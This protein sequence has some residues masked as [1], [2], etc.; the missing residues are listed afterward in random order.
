MARDFDGIDDFLRVSSSAISAYPFTMAGWFNSDDVTSAQ[1]IIQIS[2]VAANGVYYRL[3]LNATTLSADARN[4]SP[5]AA[6]STG[7][8]VNDTWHHACGVYTSNTSRDCY[9]DGGDKGSNIVSVTFNANTDTMTIGRLDRDEPIQEFS[10]PLAEA[11]IWN[12]ALS[13]GEIEAL[14]DGYSP[15]LIR[16]SALVY[17]PNLI[18]DIF[19]HLGNAISVTGTTVVAHTQIRYPA[20]RSIITAPAAA[21]GDGTD[22]PWPQPVVPPSRPVQV[23]GY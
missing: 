3:L 7:T 1:T 8:P 11:A 13:L 14:A 12:V 5:K 21:G 9:L 22:F 4:T 2:E 6:V 17:H 23:V 16:P 10:G 19:D 18:R 20:P 15:L